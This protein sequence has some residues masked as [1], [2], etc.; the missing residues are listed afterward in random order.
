MIYYGLATASIGSEQVDLEFEWSSPK[1]AR[2]SKRN[3]LEHL[4]KT[5]YV[6]ILG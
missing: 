4:V 5:S 2:V 1:F 6:E 3:A